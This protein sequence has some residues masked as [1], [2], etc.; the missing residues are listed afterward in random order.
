MI[1]ISIHVN[2]TSTELA[3]RV[4][5]DFPFHPMEKSS[6]NILANPVFMKSKFP[7]WYLTIIYKNTGKLFPL[8]VSLAQ[9]F[10][11]FYTVVEIKNAIQKIVVKKEQ[12]NVQIEC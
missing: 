2:S 9:M 5:L 12:K 8:V 10:L 7:H 11:P 3:K 6:T 4:H 1:V